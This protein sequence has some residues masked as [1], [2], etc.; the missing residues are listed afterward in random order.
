MAKQ[1]RQTTQPIAWF[2]DLY[3]RD[4]LDLDPSYQRRSVWNQSYKDYFIDTLLLNYPAPAIFLFEE[5]SEDGTGRYAVVDGKQRL[6]AVFEFL[7]DKFAAPEIASVTRLRERYFSD[8]SS[9][10]KK[11]FYGYQ[12]SIE[13][14]P[15]TDE[16]TLNNI[17]D[18]INRNV[19]KLTPQELRHAKYSGVFA[20]AAERLSEQMNRELPTGFPNI[21]TASRRQMK[22]VE[23]V[24][25][26]LL[27]IE[28]G[29]GSFSQKDLDVAYAERDDDWEEQARVESEFAAVLS[30]ISNC[31]S[32]ILAGPSRRIRNQADFYSFFAAIHNL[33][34]NGMAPAPTLIVQRLDAFMEL[35]S[36][37]SSRT[38]NALAARY[39][40]AA[41]SASNDL[42]QRR[43]RVSIIERI[44]T[45]KG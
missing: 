22:D 13:F 19:A 11:N 27:M 40:E 20:E 31:A 9:E 37:D 24:V 18:R 38:D 42:S 35:V 2:W 29:V 26:L 33:Q 4:L 44:L 32:E 30:A 8:F 28:T 21:A 23:L 14:L 39:Y 36:D 10:D 5:I 12:F 25:Q 17:F 1:R 34:M 16:G 43:D 6:T 15:A 45:G 7:E 3:R 41:R